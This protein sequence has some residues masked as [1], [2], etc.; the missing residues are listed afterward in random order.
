MED[1]P[2]EH[3]RDLETS[4]SELYAARSEFSRVELA[5]RSGVPEHEVLVFL[6]QLCKEESLRAKVNVRCPECDQDHGTFTNKGSIPTE[7]IHCF[8]D[9]EFDPRE[10]TNWA[11]VYEFLEDEDFFQIPFTNMSDS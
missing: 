9:T 8:C 7:P 2:S 6:T 10:R 4:L 3:Y 11:V 5:Q 1:I